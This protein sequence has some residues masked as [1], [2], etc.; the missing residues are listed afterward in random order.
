MELRNINEGPQPD[1]LFE[2]ASDYQKMTP[3]YMGKD[4]NASRPQ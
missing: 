1:T 4:K 3:Q 2:V